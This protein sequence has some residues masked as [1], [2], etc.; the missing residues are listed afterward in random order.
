MPV[1]YVGR[2]EGKQHED[3]KPDKENLLRLQIDHFQ[4]E[5][6]AP[7][8]NDVEQ[9]RIRGSEIDIPIHK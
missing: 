4:K 3:K 2:P 9:R 1:E 6:T 8:F 5:R 7:T